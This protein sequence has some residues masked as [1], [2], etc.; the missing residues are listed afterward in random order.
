M[1][2]YVNWSWASEHVQNE[3]TNGEYVSSE[4]TL[5]LAGPSRLSML[6]GS[7]E[8]SSSS[9]SLIP[10]GLIQNVGITQQRQLNR[11]FE[12]GSK[13]AYFVPGR[14]FSNFTIGRILFYGPSLLRLLYALA[15]IGD[16]QKLGNYGTPLN[17]DEDANNDPVSTPTE[18]GKLFQDST[19]QLAP[20]AGGTTG[21]T[22]NRDFFI[23]LASEL[24]NV[25]F[26]MA[27]IFKDTRN[28]PYG[29]VF[30]EDCYIE[31]HNM[32]VDANAVVIGESATGQF[33]SLAPI[34]LASG[35]LFGPPA[36]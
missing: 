23:N 5:V 31:T 4:S 27:L 3:I 6:S 32:G 8:S 11:L 35:A 17:I 29:A 2:S 26:G 9:N 25:P 13:R 12:I 10:L 22:Q 16:G 20:G 18:Y 14:L 15:P 19:L 24:F 33:D 36:P 7:L 30:L 1:S 28:R 21:D 34:Q